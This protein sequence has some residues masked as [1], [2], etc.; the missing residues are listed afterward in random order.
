MTPIGTPSRRSGTAS[1]SGSLRCGRARLVR[2]RDRF[3]N[4]EFGLFCAPMGNCL[5]SDSSTP[6]TDFLVS[7]TQICSLEIGTITFRHPGEGPTG[8]LLHV[9][10]GACCMRCSYAKQ[11]A[12]RTRAN[13]RRAR[14]RATDPISR[15]HY[16]EMAAQAAVPASIGCSV[17]LRRQVQNAV[18]DHRRNDCLNK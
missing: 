18:R 6:V 1:W 2:I 3:E 14:E 16:R 15:Q 10:W 11:G 12:F 5:R 7:R 4:R 9:E 17:A 8:Q 13:V